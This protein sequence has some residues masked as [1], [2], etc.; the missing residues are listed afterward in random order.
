VDTY[1]ARADADRARKLADT[2]S[3][4]TIEIRFLDG[5]TET[6]Q[7]AFAAAADRWARVIVGD[8]PEVRIGDDVIDD[9]L[10]IAQGKKIDGPG[11]VL[12]SARPT[13][14]RVAPDGSLLQPCRGEMSFDVADLAEMAADGTLGDVIT[15]EM[16]HVL[17]IGGSLWD[18]RRLV[19][20]GPDSPAALEDP[21]FVGAAAMA[22]YGRLTG[23][24]GAP[25][26][27][28]PV[29]NRGGSGTARSH[30]REGVFDAELM[31]GFVDPAG[32]PMSRVTVGCLE[33]L[34]Y[35]V[36]YAAADPYTLP[37][38]ALLAA[39]RD[40]RPRVVHPHPA[41]GTHL[42]AAEADPVLVVVK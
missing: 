29:E 28:V 1:V 14:L 37:S 33:D 19:V 40:R 3:P 22:E 16:G 21:V 23:G 10:I 17:G 34:G 4:F 27:P 35:Q 24:D 32:N 30:W 9:V 7:A 38:P 26:R 41:P 13:H 6:E 20:P 8:L 12:G 15:H 11:H 2:E 39:R 18:R 25:P 31:T 42:V 5:L 36:D